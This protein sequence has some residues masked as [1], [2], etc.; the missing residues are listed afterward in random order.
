V[1]TVANQMA[2]IFARLG[3]RSRLELFAWAAR[4]ARREEKA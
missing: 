3:V 4:R 1:R 2:S